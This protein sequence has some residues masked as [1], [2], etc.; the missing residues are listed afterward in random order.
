M[1]SAQCDIAALLQCNLQKKL[2]KTV[3]NRTV[4]MYNLYLYCQG[5]DRILL[6][7]TEATRDWFTAITEAANRSRYTATA[8]FNPPQAKLFKKLLFIGK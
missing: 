1:Y 7:R 6:R 5:E 2:S 8:H 4:V 3:L